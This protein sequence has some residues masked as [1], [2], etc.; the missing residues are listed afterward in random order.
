[1]HR[2]AKCDEFKRYEHFHSLITD[3]QTD[4]HSDYSVAPRAVQSN[5][6]SYEG[7]NM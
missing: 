7:F 5:N 4:S 1:M 3:R 2:Y 6:Q